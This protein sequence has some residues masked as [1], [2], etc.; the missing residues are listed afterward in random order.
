MHDTPHKGLFIEDARFDSSG[1]VRVQNIRDLI[2]WLLRDT[3]GW[4]PDRIDSE[5]RG[6]DRRDV[7][8]AAPVPLFWIYVTA[9][10]AT[11][12]VV[13][14]REDIYNLDG[15]EAYTASIP[16]APL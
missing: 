7:R 4:T 14:F 13:N 15:L 16:A 3:Q 11:D 8:L 2:V 1:C 6:N 12:G 9:W 5:L 10:A